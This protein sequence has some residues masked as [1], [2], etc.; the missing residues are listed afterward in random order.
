MLLLN[1]EN[2]FNLIFTVCTISVIPL[3]CES[4]DGVFYAFYQS[5]ND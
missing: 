4:Y 1:E 2:T 5:E 3:D